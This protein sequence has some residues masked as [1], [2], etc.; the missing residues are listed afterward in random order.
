MAP[1]SVDLHK[2]TRQHVA[3][4]FSSP[5]LRYV[6]LNANDERLRSL[7]YDTWNDPVALSGLD[8][9]VVKPISQGWLDD[10]NTKLEKALLHVVITL[11]P[12]DGESI[13]TVIG[14]ISLS[15][16]V[17]LRTVISRRSLL[18]VNIMREYQG[19]GYGKEAANWA[20]DWGFSQAGLHTIALSVMAFNEPAIHLYK[21]IG[22]VQEGCAREARYLNRKWYDILHFSMT[23]NE[24][25]KLRGIQNGA[26][27]EQQ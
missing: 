3:T 16:E 26:Q 2:A 14:D 15:S 1:P 5:N 9:T 25:E 27:S 20:L 17:S 18:G 24:W 13:G 11:P 4:A 19:K 10:L 23:E 6:S 8:G 22:F 21:S 12:K 7:A